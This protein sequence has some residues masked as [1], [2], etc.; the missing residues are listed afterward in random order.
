MNLFRISNVREKIL[1]QNQKGNLINKYIIN[2]QI[3]YKKKNIYNYKDTANLNYNIV[4]KT[5]P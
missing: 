2:N 3:I 1:F 4:L 5:M